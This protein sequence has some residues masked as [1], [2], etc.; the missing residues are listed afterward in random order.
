LDDAARTIQ[1][2][3]VHELDPIMTR[4]IRTQFLL[5]RNGCHITYDAH[6]LFDYINQSGDVYDP[7]A[8]E[9]IQRHERMRLER[10]CNKRLSS[11]KQLAFQFKNEIDRRSLFSYLL[12]EIAEKEHE[13]G[14][15]YEAIVNIRS[16]SLG[17]DLGCVLQM[18][19][20]VRECDE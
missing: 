12:N 3:I 16:V 10:V 11:D 9:F 18:L 20:R 5:F 15:S 6:T 4:P 7:V 14:D 17:N 8:R 1:R 13:G 2:I 19:Q